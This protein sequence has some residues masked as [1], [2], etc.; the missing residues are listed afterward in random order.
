MKILSLFDFTGLFS[1]P[2]HEAGYEVYQID[3]KHG[4]N[5]LE[6]GRTWVR[7]NGPW[8][9]VLAAPPCDDFASSGARWWAEKDEK[10]V[11]AKS[12]K[13]IEHTLNVIEWAEPAWWALENPVGRIAKLCPRLKRFGPRYFHPCWYGGWLNPPGDHYTKK[14]GLYG[15]FRMPVPKHVDPVY[16]TLANGMRGSWMW[17]NLG[18]GSERTKELRS[19]TPLGFAKAFFDSN[20]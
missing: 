9:G 15:R 18:G 17:A 4:D 3:I 12:V 2:Y 19:A 13:L 16:I 14:T 20:R 7:R 6:L 8:R 11:T 5:V 10:G 1:K